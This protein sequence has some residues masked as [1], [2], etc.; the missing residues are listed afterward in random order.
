MRTGKDGRKDGKKEG[1]TEIPM[2]LDR[3]KRTLKKTPAMRIRS[4]W[5]NCART[6]MPEGRK[7][8]KEGRQG[9]KEVKDM[10]IYIFIHICYTHT[11]THIYI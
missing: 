7:E 9:R 6:K 5:R 8:V 11:H 4:A 10:Y 1:R 2:N 3:L